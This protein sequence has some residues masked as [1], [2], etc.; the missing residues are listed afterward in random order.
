MLF[1]RLI[2]ILCTHL[3]EDPNIKIMTGTHFVSGIGRAPRQG[4]F[5]GPLSP[6]LHQAVTGGGHAKGI[7]KAYWL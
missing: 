5:P 2:K 4:G 6:D 7:E 3:Y 1:N